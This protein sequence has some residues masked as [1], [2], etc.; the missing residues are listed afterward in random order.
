[1]DL[2]EF[3]SRS[4]LTM[5]NRSSSSNDFNNFAKVMEEFHNSTIYFLR[6]A[7]DPKRTFVV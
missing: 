3:V 2:W 5:I 6:S 7:H 1:M 4:V